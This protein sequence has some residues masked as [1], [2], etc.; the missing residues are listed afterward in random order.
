MTKHGDTNIR[1]PMPPPTK[2]HWPKGR[3]VRVESEEIEE[4]LEDYV[5]PIP[6]IRT[7]RS[8]KAIHDYRCTHRHCEWCGRT[9]ALQVHHLK[10]RGAGGAGGGDEAHNLIALCYEHH[11]KAHREPGFNQRLKEMKIRRG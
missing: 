8:L 11:M 5:K 10:T 1:S 9:Y 4:G 7:L 2:C 3:R 6:K